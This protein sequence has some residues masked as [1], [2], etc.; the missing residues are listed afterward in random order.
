MSLLQCYF[1]LDTGQN[2]SLL[3]LS[4]PLQADSCVLKCSVHVLK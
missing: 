3:A 4:P 1:F 2:S